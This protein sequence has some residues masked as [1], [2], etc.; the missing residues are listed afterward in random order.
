[1]KPGFTL[2]EI[3]ITLAILGILLTIS[4]PSLQSLIQSSNRKEAILLLTKIQYQQEQWRARHQNY[5]SL[6]ELKQSVV[7][8]NQLY[9]FQIKLL[10]KDNYRLIA[11]PVNKQKTDACGAYAM[12]KF[13]PVE[14]TDSG[15]VYASLDCWQL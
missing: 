7:S 1:M 5:A 6:S 15:D 9:Q 4:Y 13:G 14:K 2:V 10:D 12:D 11:K 8:E 3:L